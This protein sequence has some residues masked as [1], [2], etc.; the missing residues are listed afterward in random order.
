MQSIIARII[1]SALIVLPRMPSTLLSANPGLMFQVKE[2][3]QKFS[4]SIGSGT[5]SVMS[6][7][8]PF[9]VEAVLEGS[10]NPAQKEIGV[11]LHPRV[12]PLVRSMPHVESLSLFKAEEPQDEAEA[13]STLGLTYAHPNQL[14]II[15][16]VSMTDP[17]DSYPTQNFRDN[18]LP[19]L[20]PPKEQISVI[21][22]SPPPPS[23]N[24]LNMLESTGSTIGLHST[25]AVSKMSSDN[26]GGLSTIVS[27]PVLFTKEDEQDGD[28]E[29]PLIDIDSDSEDEATD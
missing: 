8:L 20:E 25:V 26:T 13:L 12:P 2:K 4:V 17:T 27:N 24:P 7:S 19:L 22:T 21:P 14:Q 3:I 5:S 6:K 1:I 11:L 29:M 9:V 15:P 23:T 18:T 16:D 28:E 10:N